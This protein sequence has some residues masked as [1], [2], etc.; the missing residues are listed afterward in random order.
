MIQSQRID[1]NARP[2]KVKG[3]GSV[4]LVLKKMIHNGVKFYPPRIVAG[5]LEYDKV[6]MHHTEAQL[7]NYS[8]SIT[9]EH[10]IRKGMLV[11]PDDIRH[12]N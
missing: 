9:E 2:I 12:N 11:H 1:R 10:K 5:K 4:Y 8:G 7:W 6:R 3:H